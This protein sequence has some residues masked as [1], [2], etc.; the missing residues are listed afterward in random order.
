[1]CSRLLYFH[2]V[3][4]NVKI[5]LHKAE[6]LLSSD[7][8]TG[9]QSTVLCTAAIT[10]YSEVHHESGLDRL[11]ALNRHISHIKSQRI[12]GTLKHPSAVSRFNANGLEG[13]RQILIRREGKI[14]NIW[15]SFLKELP[16]LPNLLQRGDNTPSEERRICRADRR[17]Q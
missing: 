14:R 10:N 15:R 13:K 4:L 5:R 16:L 11:C 2:T 8:C 9:S 6:R 7:V 12:R 1:M 3:S 17:L